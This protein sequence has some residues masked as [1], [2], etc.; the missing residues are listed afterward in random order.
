MQNASQRTVEQHPKMWFFFSLL[1]NTGKYQFKLSCRLEEKK[2]EREEKKRKKGE[3]KEGR[4]QTKNSFSTGLSITPN[5]I[6]RKQGAAR[7]E[8]WELELE[9][10]VA[11][12]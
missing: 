11:P 6:Q 4:K 10:V 2:K 12:T 1:T 5:V 8:L 3:G 9:G 7:W